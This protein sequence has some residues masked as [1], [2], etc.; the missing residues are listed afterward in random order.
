[1]RNLL[2]NRKLIWAMALW[3]ALISLPP[4][5]ADAMPSDSVTVVGASAM[6]EAQIGQILSVLSQPRAQAHLVMMGIKR[7]ELQSRLS[8]LDDRELAAV[9]RRAEAIKAG[10]DGLGIV[11]AIL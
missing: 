9:S 4:S 2:L 10:G 6:R 11:I 3:S 8:R 1:M 5:G 7:D